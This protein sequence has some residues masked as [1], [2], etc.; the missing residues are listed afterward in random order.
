MHHKKLR[1][2]RGAPEIK[3]G[4]VR[5]LKYGGGGRDRENRHCFGPPIG[6]FP[7]IFWDTKIAIKFLKTNNRG[8]SRK[9]APGGP[10]RSGALSRVAAVF[11][12]PLSVRAPP[13]HRGAMAPFPDSEPDRVPFGF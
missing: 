8:G 12:S 13:D 11:Q 7:P 6:G 3:I 2:G 9:I 10:N 1:R 4:G 5:K